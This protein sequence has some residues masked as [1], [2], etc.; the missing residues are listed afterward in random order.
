MNHSRRYR[1]DWLI[2]KC[3]KDPI[4]MTKDQFTVKIHRVRQLGQDNLV[5]PGQTAWNQPQERTLRNLPREIK[6]VDSRPD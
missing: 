3:L 1:K 6:A 5:I 4:V 2:L